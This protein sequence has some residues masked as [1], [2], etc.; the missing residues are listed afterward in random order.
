MANSRN[1]ILGQNPRTAIPR[2]GGPLG[3]NGDAADP[4]APDWLLGD[5]PGPLGNGDHADPNSRMFGQKH[6]PGPDV[7]EFRQRAAGDF[8][9]SSPIHVV[10]RSNPNVSIEFEAKD[11]SI[12]TA[13]YTDAKPISKNLSMKPSLPG[14]PDSPM[15][16][17][18]V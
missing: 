8:L 3:T 12:G 1:P 10:E 11:L 15:A 14:H 18:N 17:A 13:R 4:D 5:T 7:G 6:L 16:H 9:E 2:T